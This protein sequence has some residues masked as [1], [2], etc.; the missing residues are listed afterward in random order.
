MSQM[1]RE[2]KNEALNSN[3]FLF[4]FME[5]LAPD[6]GSS[7]L[8]SLFQSCVFLKKAHCSDPLGDDH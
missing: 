7:T 2:E 8:F 5:E 4:G 6:R 1:L 3:H